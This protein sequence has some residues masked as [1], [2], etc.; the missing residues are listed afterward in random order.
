MYFE[1]IEDE[2]MDEESGG[3]GWDDSSLRQAQMA[4]VG[5]TFS[6]ARAPQSVEAKLG[7][8]RR[9]K[10][11]DHSKGSPY[12]S[13]PPSVASDASFPTS[14]GSSSGTGL[15]GRTK[16]DDLG[17]D[18]KYIAQEAKVCF[19]VWLAMKDAFL[20]ATTATEVAT[21]IFL[22]LRYEIRLLAAAKVQSQYDISPKLSV[23][24]I[25]KK[26]TLLKKNLNYTFLQPDPKLICIF[27]TVCGFLLTV[28]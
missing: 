15:R 6:I 12:P 10:N 2:D 24:D 9:F 8:R 20:D 17:N 16:L 18:S 25:S 7:P 1:D 23:D 14:A 19:R 22:H 13:A 3:G 28:L 27:A 11:S 5:P 26:I 21:K 4:S